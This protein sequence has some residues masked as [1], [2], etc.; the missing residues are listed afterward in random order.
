MSTFVICPPQPSDAEG[1]ATVF[2]LSCEYAYRPI[3]P[4]AL[5]SRYTPAKQVER[6]TNH[7]RESSSLNQLMVATSK[8]S[9]RVLGFIEVGPSDESNV[10]EIHYLFVLPSFSGTGIGAALLRSGEHWLMSR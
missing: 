1:I 7:V 3:F 9:N 5:I 10:G 8:D 6:W 4:P 2:A